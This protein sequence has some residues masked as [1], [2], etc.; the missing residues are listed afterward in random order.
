MQL[1]KSCNGL[2]WC[3]VITQPHTD[4]IWSKHKMFRVAWKWNDLALSKTETTLA[5]PWGEAWLKSSSKLDLNQTDGTMCVSSEWGRDCPS[6]RFPAHSSLMIYSQ[7]WTHSR[8]T[9]DCQNTITRLQSQVPNPVGVKWALKS[10]FLIY[11]QV[12]M[13]VVKEPYFDST[14]QFQGSANFFWQGPKSPFSFWCTTL[15]V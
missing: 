7:T 12:T 8:I 3:Q 1:D 2:K 15:H 6:P 4:L 10:A 13:P 5:P 11:P 14:D 9:E